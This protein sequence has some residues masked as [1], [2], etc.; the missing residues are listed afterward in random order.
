MY[1][2]TQINPETWQDNAILAQFYD[3]LATKPYCSN[4]KTYSHIRTKSHA[5]KH[6]YIQPNHPA[7]C[8]WLV[9]DI[10]DPQALFA[11]C[12]NNL[13][14]PQIIIKNPLNGHAHYAYRLTTAVGL[15]GNSSHKAIEYLAVVQQ[16]LR[17]AL[18]ADR[19][20]SG[21]LIKNPCNPLHDV[22]LTGSQPSY[23][24][25][26]LAEHLDLESV[27]TTQAQA[28]NDDGYGRNVS[29]FNHVRFYAY[30]IAYDHNQTELEA[31][32]MEVAE[33]YNTRF[34]M[35]LLYNELRHIVRSVAK[36]CKNK[37]TGHYQAF[38]ER[39]RERVIKRWGDN[40]EKRKQAKILKNEGLSVRDI[41]KRL[42]VGKSTV[43]RWLK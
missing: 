19:S 16:A 23:T 9:F 4:D 22:Y 10:D 42:N 33:N 7:I 26:E 1:A 20:Y 24:L 37:Y 31:I 11:F 43:S 39:Q 28:C 18:G 34:D 6:A 25:A 15:W 21:N 5:I 27:K 17:L 41:A 3:D 30:P 36:Y 32:L 35:P 14:R 13:P 12:D 2:I 8:K 29:T 40:T 38:S